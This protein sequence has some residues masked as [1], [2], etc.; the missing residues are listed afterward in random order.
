M[1]DE[2][3]AVQKQQRSY[4]LLEKLEV[5]PA[6]RVCVGSRYGMVC[7]GRRPQQS[8]LTEVHGAQ[9]VQSQRVEHLPVMHD[10]WWEDH[11]EHGL[12]YAN[13]RWTR[14]ES[15]VYFFGRSLCRL[16]TARLP[17]GIAQAAAGA[18]GWYIVGQD[19]HVYSYSWE[20]QPRWEWKLPPRV[21]RR[22]EDLVEFA[23]GT[24][25]RPPLIAAKDDRIWVSSGAQLRCL[26]DGGKELWCQALPCKPNPSWNLS[27][28]LL[29][30]RLSKPNMQFVQEGMQV[31][32]CFR[33]EWDSRREQ[34]G[35]E[36]G[37]WLREEESADDQDGIEDIEVASALEAGPHTVFVGTC[38]GEL[39][40][41][42]RTGDLQT[43]L[44]LGEGAVWTLC[45]NQDGLHAAQSG[46]ELIYFEEGQISGRSSHRHERPSIAAS[47]GGM[48]MWTRHETWT[49]D[50][51]GVVQWAAAWAKPVVACVPLT[52]GF[53]VLAGSCAYRFTGCAPHGRGTEQN[54]VSSQIPE[55]DHTTIRANGHCQERRSGAAGGS[56]AS[57]RAS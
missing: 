2:P 12:G 50:V 30:T 14:Q 52:E 32:A 47:K 19:E 48:I 21:Q 46:D 4:T 42:S 6:P 54:S 11:L 25:R 33:W 22:R 10:F 36:R 38:G 51:R 49:A 7:L 43:R 8:I 40:G 20:G 3:F 37:M 28:E 44:R 34:P 16:G 9:W 31:G 45:V 13:G 24:C 23:M 1:A 5:K 18:Q 29:R 27:D 15:Q 56:C 53:A 55:D 41:W 39:L 57:S 35:C 26:D 17:H